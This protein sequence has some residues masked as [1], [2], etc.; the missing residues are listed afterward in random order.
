MAHQAVRDFPDIQLTKSLMVGNNMSDMGFGKNA[1]MKTI[2]LKTTSPDLN[3]PHPDIDL[4]F[5]NLDELA[6]A[7]KK[8]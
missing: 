3:L 8:S 7:L 4:Y 6:E 5:N 2:F 1:G